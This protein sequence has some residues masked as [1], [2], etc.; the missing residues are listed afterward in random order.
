MSDL[1]DKFLDEF[2]DN[3]CLGIMYERDVVIRFGDSAYCS[4]KEFEL[5]EYV[6]RLS[7]FEEVTCN[8]VGIVECA[9]EVETRNLV[10]GQQLSEGLVVNLCPKWVTSCPCHSTAHKI[11][12]TLSKSDVARWERISRLVQRKY[13]GLVGQLTGIPTYKDQENTRISEPTTSTCNAD[14]SDEISAGAR[15]GDSSV[16]K[17]AHATRFV[18]DPSGSANISSA[19][20]CSQI[21]HHMQDGPE[22]EVE[23]RETETLGLRKTTEAHGSSASATEPGQ[24]QVEVFHEKNDLLP[25]YSF[26]ISYGH[27]MPEKVLSRAVN[28]N[29]DDFRNFL[30]AWAYGIKSTDAFTWIL[31]AILLGL[32]TAYGGIHLSI[33]GYEFPTEKERWLWRVASLNV[34]AFGWFFVICWLLSHSFDSI[35]N[36]M[37]CD[38]LPEATFLWPLFIMLCL[39]ILFCAASRVF[40]VVESFISL[41][42]VPI[43]VYAAIP[44][45]QYIPHIY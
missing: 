30:D 9:S 13:P 15:L 12:L 16:E 25:R 42:T 11:R 37:V 19:S 5:A 22:I 41:R 39:A 27:F 35:E 31:L 6:S 3:L 20:L 43:G 28:F 18:T 24:R 32:M 26:A 44:W 36:G 45:A 40:I 4:V 7:S 21:S 17:Y 23:H 2:L 10:S 14:N 34:T 8:K 29:L 38:I 33:W 1:D